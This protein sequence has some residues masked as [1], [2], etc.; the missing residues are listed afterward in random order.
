MRL[1][2]STGSVSDLLEDLIHN[3]QTLVAQKPIT[4]IRDFESKSLG[5]LPLDFGKLRQIIFNLISNA[6]KFTASGTISIIAR[7]NIDNLE[8][9][10]RDTGV[11]ISTENQEFLFTEFYQ[12]KTSH[13]GGTGL[14]LALCKKLVHLMNGEISLTS[15]RG[16]GCSVSLIIPLN[17]AI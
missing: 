3:L 9:T 14:G 5:S 1:Q 2:L 13:Q 16:G 11:G 7:R 8:V 6:A 10:I 12:V 15:S 17:L 4:I